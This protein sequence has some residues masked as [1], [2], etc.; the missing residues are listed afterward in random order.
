MFCWE[1]G[2]DNFEKKCADP[3]AD[4]EPLEVKIFVKINYLDDIL[5]TD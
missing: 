2:G 4:V 1:G 3:I 5:F